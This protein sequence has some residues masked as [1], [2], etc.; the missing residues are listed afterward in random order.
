[1]AFEQAYQQY[2]QA[3]GVPGDLLQ[4]IAQ[5]ES[6]GDPSAINRWDTNAQAGTPSAGLMQFIQP[7]FDSFYDQARASR[8][9]LFAELGQKDWMNPKQQIATAAWAIGQGKGSHWSTYD[10][11]KAGE[12]ATTTTS[13]GSSKGMSGPINYGQFQPQE[14][15]DA[16]PTPGATPQQTLM[17]MV[18]A[19]DP[20]IGGALAAQ[21]AQPVRRTSAGGKG[22]NFFSG[23]D[24]DPNVGYEWDIP[25][26]EGEDVWQWIQRVGQQK[27]GLRND[28]GMGQLTGGQHSA[29]SLHY[30]G[31]AVDWGDALND[32]AVLSQ[33]AEY[34]RGIP[35]VSEVIWQA[36]GHYDH[37]HVGF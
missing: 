2:G 23:G 26:R 11:A 13:D 33:A 22:Q 37:L 18:F 28:P 21:S 36:P 12:G 5:L 24:F 7:T 27:F 31:R 34:F 9:E 4:R 8:P 14:S 1:M 30:S 17:K 10:R 6:S 25:R 3:F 15:G 32:P 29:G 16:T 20:K 35:G 19:E